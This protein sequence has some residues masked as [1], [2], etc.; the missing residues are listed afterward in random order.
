MSL[1]MKQFG[2]PFANG[3]WRADLLLLSK[4]QPIDVVFT[5][6]FANTR[7]IIMSINIYK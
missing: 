2:S 1:H 6:M 4:K 5:P 3:K 7:M